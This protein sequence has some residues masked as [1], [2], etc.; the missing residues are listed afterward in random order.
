MKLYKSL[1]AC[2]ALAVSSVALTSCDEELAVPPLNIP[3][4]PEGIVANTTI[5]DFKAK[6]WSTETNYCTEVGKTDDGE[7]VI[8]C[9]H[10]IANDEGGNIYQT[11]VF[12]DATDALTVS[13][14]TTNSSG[15]LPN[16]YTKYKVGEEF[17]IN[18]TG[19]YAGKY[20]GLFQLGSAGSYN[21]TPQ[22]DR[23]D[24]Q[25]FLDHTYLNGLPDLSKVTVLETTIPELLAATS[26][27]DQQRLQS[28]RV[29]IKDVSWIGGGTEN[30]GVVGTNSSAESRYLIDAKGNKITV[31]NSN[32]SDFV[33]QLL[34][35]GHGDVVAILSQFN[36]TWQLI[37]QLPS[38]CID[39]GGESYAPQV[40]GEGTA[41]APYGVSSVLAGASGEAWVTGY[42]V[43]WIDGMAL[44]TGA[45]FN[46]TATVNSNLLLAASPDVTDVAQCIP[47]QLPT[48]D[49]RNALN[50]KDNP[51][52]YQKQVT[53]KG[54]LETY[55]G[56][57]GVKSVTLYAWGDKGNES[58][59]TPDV[60][61]PPAGDGD[62]SA[63]KPFDVAQIL[64]GATG[65][66]VW[67]TG[68]IVGA[69]NDKSISDAAFVGPFALKTNILI[70]ATAGETDINKCVPVQLPA[71]ALRDA[72]N[73]VDNADN[74]GKKITLKGNLE[75]YFGVAGIKSAT[76]YTWGTASE[77]P[78]ATGA[79]FRKVTSITSG[80]QYLIV[81][82]G[83]CA[84]LDTRNYGYLKV[85]DVTDNNGV[86]SGVDPANAYTFTAVSG[87]YNITMTDGRYVYQTGN[88]DSFNFSTSA[89]NGSVWTL[90]AQSDGTFK[91]TNASTNK[92][93]QFDSDYGTYGCYV[94]DKGEL[95]ALYEKVD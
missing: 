70:A 66:A 24:S 54:S 3:T 2:M 37:F 87:G 62:G 84:L 21:G 4:L 89:D 1:L 55:F 35:A 6:Y 32:Y 27:E 13:V 58:G 79:N 34:P 59:T 42:I 5:A 80:K 69:I 48:G 25:T 78:P 65:T 74:F 67:S 18:V 57:A 85:T 43:G 33:D 41:E 23:M 64:G 46:S 73:L 61:T 8:L 63:E 72:V 10:I 56:A 16:L 71:G 9:G 95:P 45:N 28:R 29:S 15:V 39:F 90:E 14:K 38:D 44:A 51:G 11:L 52:N 81:A 94:D 47:I 50:L 60:P 53:L 82:A 22:T 77:N 83:K 40:V 12:E 26:V 91:I 30:W 19:L 92:Y 31:R 88:Y 49:I 75:K 17:Y 68:Y 93:I 20:A 7:D 76:E 36:G 86:I